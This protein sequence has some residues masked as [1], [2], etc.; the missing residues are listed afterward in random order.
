MYEY[1]FSDEDY[2]MYGIMY[3]EDT[4]HVF[5]EDHF[6]P[7]WTPLGRRPYYQMRGKRITEE[8]AFEVISRTDCLFSQELELENCIYSI[9]FDN[10]WFASNRGG[11]RG[12]VHPNGIVGTNDIMSKYPTVSEFAEELAI[13]LYEFP[14]LDLMIGITWWD[15]LSTERSDLIHNCLMKS[16]YEIYDRLRFVEYD[17]FCQ[18][19]EAG[20]WVHDRKVEIVDEESAVKLYRQY[21]EKYGEENRKVYFPDYYNK[22]QPDIVTMSYLKKCLLKYGITDPEALLKEKVRPYVLKDVMQYQ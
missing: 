9:N 17:N 1:K 4:V 6:S 2:D 8:Q 20:I 22:F 21:E 3:S 5:V 19:L 13:Y 12:W 16:D 18:N 15:E 10:N 7:D 11:R 14:F